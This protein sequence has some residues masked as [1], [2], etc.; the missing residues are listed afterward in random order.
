MRAPI[1]PF[2]H[3]RP[4]PDCLDE[5]TLPVAEAVRGLAGDLPVEEVVYV[6]TDPAIADTAAFV[7]HF[8]QELLDTS[9]NCVVVAAKR[10]GGTTL[11]ACLVLSGARVDVN[12]TVRRHLGARKVSFAPMATAVELTGMEYG[13][14]TPLGLPADWA[15]LVD[16][17]V[18]ELPHVLVGSGSRRGKLIVPGRFFARLPGAELVAGL[19]VGS[20]PDVR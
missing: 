19:A 10:G 17:A 16:P 3:V 18:A 6:D 11:A 1:G 9:A 13:G 7:A 20:G 8:G 15:L 12:G 14:I 5:L 4:A 2:T